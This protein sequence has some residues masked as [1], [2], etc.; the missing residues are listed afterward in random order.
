MQKF[1]ILLIV[2]M[3]TNLCQAQ[4]FV[5]SSE[6]QFIEEAIK[7]GLFVAKQSF[8]ICDK[9]TGDLFGLNGKK[10]FGIQYSLGV[11]VPNGF[12]LTD[13]AIRPW[14]YDSKFGKYRDKYD[15][16]F[17]QA[18]FAELKESS[19]KYDSLAY[20]IA[21]QEIVID[22]TLYR[23]PS[24]LFG[25]AGFRLENTLGKKEGWVVWITANNDTDLAMT[26]DL[27]FTIYRKDITIDQKSQSFNI[28]KPNVDRTFIGGIYV[29]PTYT[30]IGVIEFHLCGILIPYKDNWRIYCPFVGADKQPSTGAIEEEKTDDEQSELTPVTRKDEEPIKDKKKRKR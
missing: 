23:F 24:E 2:T 15:P 18:E 13:Q 19:V 27:N 11:K 20:S 1:L 12:V 9:E 8:Q 26:L 3:M 17:Y 16:I 21:Q 14:L 7:D 6:Q 5:K 30:Q 10:E 28:D 29:I 25:G 4:I 22:T